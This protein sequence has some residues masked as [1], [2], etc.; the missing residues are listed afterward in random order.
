MLIDPAGRAFTYLRLSVTDACGFSCSYCLPEGYRRPA[1]W[2][3]PL[4][5]QEVERL[6]RGLAPLGL[7]KVRL[8]GGEP[9]SRRDLVELVEAVAAVPGIETVA[10]STNG[11]RL[12]RLAAALNRAGLQAVNVSIDSLDP[13]EFAAITG[14]D[15]LE[16]VLAGVE[17]ALGAG[18]RVKVN[19]VLLR[20]CNDASVDRFLDWV[21]DTPVT[22]RFI[23]LMRTGDNQL[24][25]LRRHLGL[26]QLEARLLA[27]GFVPKAREATDGPARELTHPDK[28]GGIGLIT[29][30]A[31]DFCAS[32]NRLRVT[33]AGR[34]RLCLF[35]DRDLSLRHLLDG[36]PPEV[37]AAAVRA[38]LAGKGAGHRLAEGI[39]GNV[40]NL[41]QM[42]G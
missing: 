31:Q 20:G 6:V 30:Y 28:R 41:A 38:A 1:D 29:P 26:Q 13:A 16:E 37:L 42:G 8:T 14:K 18:L 9:T 5:V 33:S 7:R 40:R 12:A 36:R 34:L 35:G 25:F 19:A 22:V 17:A 23:E 4:S 32:C 21:T 3:A 39:T 2:E 15:G 11:S 10:L 24:Y 27:A